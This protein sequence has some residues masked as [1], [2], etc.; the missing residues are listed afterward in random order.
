MGEKKCTEIHP[1]PHV[2]IGS[3]EERLDNHQKK[4]VELADGCLGASAVLCAIPLQH[5]T[6][7]CEQLQKFDIKG[8]LIWCLFKDTY[9]ENMLDFLPA[10]L[11][12]NKRP[13]RCLRGC[14]GWTVATE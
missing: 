7:A 11:Q 14:P 12:M 8:G 13:T 5:A 10:V 3:I 4:I 9:K 1:C 6:K 2:N